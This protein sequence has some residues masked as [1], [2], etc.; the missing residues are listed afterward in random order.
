VPAKDFPTLSTPFRISAAVPRLVSRA[1]TANSVSDAPALFLLAGG[2]SVTSHDYSAS[3]RSRRRRCPGSVTLA[4]PSG[5]PSEKALFRAM[6]MQ[7]LPAA[8]F[9]LRTG[10]VSLNAP[11]LSYALKLDD[12][13]LH[14]A[15]L[16]NLSGWL[17][18]SRPPSFPPSLGVLGSRDSG[19]VPGVYDPVLRPH[20]LTRRAL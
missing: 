1:T 10:V 5:S 15:V 19:V 20:G 7:F 11:Q 17:G 13:P 8:T 14:H 2:A 3:L 9:R 12:G 18:I 6:P 16:P 4:T